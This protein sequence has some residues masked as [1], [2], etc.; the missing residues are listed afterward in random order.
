MVERWIIFENDN[1][2]EVEKIGSSSYYVYLPCK[3]KKIKQ[4]NIERNKQEIEN[5]KLETLKIQEQI[6]ESLKSRQENDERLENL[7]KLEKLR[8]ENDS[9]S[10]HL[11]EYNKC[12]PLKFEANLVNSKIYLN[13]CE[14]WKD[15]IYLVLKWM[16]TKFIEVSVLDSICPEINELGL[17]D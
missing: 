12:D 9:V 16:K 14:L 10:E 4:S 11:K 8:L 2:V 13:A 17:F 6:K 7:E 3:I 1:M 5:L 15:N